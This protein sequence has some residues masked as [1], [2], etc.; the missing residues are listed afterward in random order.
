M[1]TLS[2]FEALR[3]DSEA[4]GVFAESEPLIGF[5][6]SS[7][8][9]GDQLED[10]KITQPDRRGAEV[11]FLFDYR[12]VVQIGRSNDVDPIPAFARLPTTGIACSFVALLSES[13]A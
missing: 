10:G 13:N 2:R 1:P 6:E 4:M 8:M 7:G 5:G 12:I 3:A 9:G 11:S